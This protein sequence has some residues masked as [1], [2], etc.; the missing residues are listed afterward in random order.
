MV[1]LADFL[2]EFMSLLATSSI[3]LL[4]NTGASFHSSEVESTVCWDACA[5]LPVLGCLCFLDASE[6]E[7]S[8][9]YRKCNA[10]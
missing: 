9:R 1:V 8:S 3:S 2:A 4:Q 6:R 5:G 7:L 10:G